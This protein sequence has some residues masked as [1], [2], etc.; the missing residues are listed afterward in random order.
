MNSIYNVYVMAFARALWMCYYLTADL[1]RDSRKRR[2]TLTAVAITRVKQ[3]Q[4]L[5]L[6]LLPFFL[7]VF[8]MLL[9]NSKLANLLFLMR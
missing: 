2:T 1:Y 3:I 9:S 5:F 7:L 6:F 4:E 8:Q